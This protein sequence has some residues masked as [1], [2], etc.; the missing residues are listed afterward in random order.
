MK[1]LF[2]RL[3]GLLLLLVLKQYKK[4]AVDFAQIETAR[5]YIR[6]VQVVRNV[7]VQV[8]LL[9]VGLLVL[10]CGFLMLNVALFACVWHCIGPGTAI[11]LLA[12]LGAL[13]FLGPLCVIL[14]LGSERN[15]MRFSGASEWVS[16]LIRRPGK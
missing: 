8:A 9:I 13:Y 11:S 14:Y 12:A 3:A 16:K 15:W 7:Y 6:G 1:G 4:S 10:M 2:N 5:V